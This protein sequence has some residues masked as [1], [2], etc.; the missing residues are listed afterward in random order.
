M[1]YFCFI[2]PS[3][4]RGLF[5]ASQDRRSYRHPR[6]PLPTG[7]GSTASL[8][9][10]SGAWAAS[11]H[12]STL[13]HTL[14]Q[15]YTVT[16]PLSVWVTHTTRTGHIQTAAR[17]HT[18]GVSSTSRTAHTHAHDTHARTRH[19]QTHARAQRYKDVSRN[20]Q[21]ISRDLTHSHFSPSTYCLSLSNSETHTDMSIWRL[22]RS[23]LWIT[24][25]ITT[26]TT[27]MKIRAIFSSCADVRRIIVLDTIE[28]FSAM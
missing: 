27:T 21:L 16:R 15:C 17:A 25:I 10:G 5:I 24:I 13:M 6:S 2:V 8:V 9:S 19:T 7:R 20:L 11:S 4:L 18:Y 14:P 22:W 26:T 12:S 3:A 1:T 23:N 28:S